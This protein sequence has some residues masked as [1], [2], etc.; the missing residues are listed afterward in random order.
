[1]SYMFNKCHK[2]K[3]IKGINKFITNKVTNMN[4]MFQQCYELQYLN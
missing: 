4:T 3:A 2:L 1:M